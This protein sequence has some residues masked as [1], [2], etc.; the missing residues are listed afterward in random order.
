MSTT[1]DSE[2]SAKVIDRLL[3][4]FQEPEHSGMQY[5]CF[6]YGI[7][8]KDLFLYACRH[9]EV[10][11]GASTSPAKLL[12]VKDRQKRKHYLETICLLAKIHLSTA[13]ECPRLRDLP[14]QSA[15][16]D[17][18]LAI[19]LYDNYSIYRYEAKERRDELLARI[20]EELEIP[21]SDEAMWF[22][23]N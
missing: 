13:L 23:V 1:S 18:E 17:Y 2:F 22:L 16:V 12:A 6:G 20:K 7:F 11:E 3:R 10:F 4:H 5:V 15:L 19:A 14:I 21:A 9:P 8:L